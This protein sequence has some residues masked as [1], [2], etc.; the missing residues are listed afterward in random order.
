MMTMWVQA[1]MSWV[2]ARGARRW[3]MGIQGMAASRMPPRVVLAKEMMAARRMP[4]K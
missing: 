4:R 3:P 1:V 2:R